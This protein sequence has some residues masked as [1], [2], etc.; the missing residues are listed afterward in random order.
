MSKG[1]RA[2]FISLFVMGA[3][4][5][6]LAQ[7]PGNSELFKTPLIPAAGAWYSPAS[8]FGGITFD[9][10]HDADHPV[11]FGEW[12]FQEDGASRT[13]FFQADMQSRSDAE[14]GSTGIYATLDSPTFTFIGRGDYG[15][16]DYLGSGTA[17][18]T[19]RSIR[20]EFHS[21][22]EATFI[23]NPG[24]P[25]ERQHHIV[26]AV[27]GLPLTAAEDYSGTWIAV[28]RWQMG[29]FR[30]LAELRLTLTAQELG[31]FQVIG[32]AAAIA[33]LP[34]PGPQSRVY[35]VAC[36]ELNGRNDPLRLDG[37][38]VFRA[39]ASECNPYSDINEYNC[40][41]GGIENPRTLIW[42]NPDETGSMANVTEGLD[43]V[44]SFYTLPDY[45]FPASYPRTFAAQDRITIRTLGPPIFSE[46]DHVEIV[47]FRL[48]DG[49]YSADPP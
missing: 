24:Q 15:D 5:I 48:P 22:R 44:T 29:D 38:E 41:P 17:Q 49:F 34:I 23:D 42:V 40:V 10:S 47:L 33:T 19:G 37:C 46:D 32:P 13:V 12:Q 39:A 43:G 3:M 35:S 27:R 14:F 6:A 16:P 45:W 25:D 31:E 30:R 11:A 36:E 21:S 20:I 8:N 1:F 26:A 7:T 9:V 4:G 28:A 18:L 2:G